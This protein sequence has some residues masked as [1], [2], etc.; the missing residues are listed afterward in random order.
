MIFFCIFIL[1]ASS[2]LSAST[3]VFISVTTLC[4][5]STWLSVDLDL[6][7][8]AVSSWAELKIIKLCATFEDTQAVNTSLGWGKICHLISV[9]GWPASWHRHASFILW[10]NTLKLNPFP[11][12][13]R[14]VMA[15]YGRFVHV[16]IDNCMPIRK[17]VTKLRAT[18]NSRVKPFKGCWKFSERITWI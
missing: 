5:S 14:F 9:Q 4:C 15:I 16:L 1:P 12:F 7:S 13:K 8:R 3:A 11:F 6:S 18:S 17:Y 10:Q 2:S